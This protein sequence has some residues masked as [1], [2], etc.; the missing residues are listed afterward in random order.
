MSSIYRKWQMA[1][2]QKLLSK[3]P[4]GGNRTTSICT[5][6]NGNRIL[7]KNICHPHQRHP[8]P[9]QKHPS[10]VPMATASSP[11]TSAT[12]T[13]GNRILT[14]GNQRLK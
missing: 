4:N 8:Y 5:L 11:K 10:S 1:L 2:L 12:L 14:N 13:N 9:H 3:F 7:I 6:T